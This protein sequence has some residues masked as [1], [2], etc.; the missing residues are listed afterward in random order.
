MFKLN[1]CLHNANNLTTTLKDMDCPD[2]AVNP[3]EPPGSTSVLMGHT[4][5][6]LLFLQLIIRGIHNMGSYASSYMYDNLLH[7]VQLFLS[8]VIIIMQPRSSQSSQLCTSTMH[9]SHYPPVYKLSRDTTA[10]P[11]TIH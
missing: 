2:I 11:N 8:L 1:V 3:T 7:I 10:R 5:S 9:C 4:T 6:V